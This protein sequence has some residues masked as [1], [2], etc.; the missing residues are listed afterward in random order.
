MELKPTDIAQN[1]QV[2]LHLTKTNNKR[3]EINKKMMML[4]KKKKRK[5]IFIPRVDEDLNSQDVCLMK[6]SSL[7]AIKRCRK[8]MIIN[9]ACFKVVN[10]N[11]LT[12]KDSDTREERVVTMEEF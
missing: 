3:V 2:K 6:G 11:P 7:V 8:F 9:S 10:L 12:V 4:D 1:D 5:K